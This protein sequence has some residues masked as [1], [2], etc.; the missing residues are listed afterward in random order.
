MSQVFGSEIFCISY[1]HAKPQHRVELIRELLKLLEPTRAE[2]G[3][4]YYELYLDNKDPNYIILPSKFI[5][6]KALDEHDKEPYIVRFL[7]GPMVNF[8]E[9]VTW[10][11]AREIKK[12]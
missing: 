12:F 3:C 10:N 1:F 7:E 2:P 11:E 5:N 8:C 6:L 9:K 4:I